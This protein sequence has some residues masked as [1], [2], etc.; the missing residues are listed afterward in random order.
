M[1]SDAP[2]SRDS[3]EQ[4]ESTHAAYRALARK[5]H[6]VAPFGGSAFHCSA[7]LQP[8]VSPICNR[9]TV[10]TFGRPGIEQS[11]A[12]WNSAIQQIENLR[13]V[14]EISGLAEVLYTHF[15]QSRHPVESAPSDA[16]DVS[17][18]QSQAQEQCSDSSNA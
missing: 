4:E 17:T 9:Q 3:D 16:S 12:E 5:F 11:P 8:A 6:S 13:Y 7:G 14:Y 1:P 15:K 18:P 10:E 2:D